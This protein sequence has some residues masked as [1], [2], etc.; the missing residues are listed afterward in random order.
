MK[1]VIAQF[2]ERVYMCY[3]CFLVILTSVHHDQK[4]VKFIKGQYGEFFFFLV[5]LISVSLTHWDVWDSTPTLCK[6]AK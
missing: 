6:E 1:C 3:S 5:I 4:V 2:S